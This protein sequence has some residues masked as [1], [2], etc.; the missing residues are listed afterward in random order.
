MYRVQP[1]KD[2][3]IGEIKKIQAKCLTEKGCA[4]PG[5][6]TAA[7]TEEE[8][9]QF[10]KENYGQWLRVAK[11]GEKIIGYIIARPVEQSEECGIT[12]DMFSTGEMPEG[13]TMVILSVAAD[14]EL[15]GK[16][17]SQYMEE[18]YMDLRDEIYV[19]LLRVLIIESRI[20]G[21]FDRVLITCPESRMKYYEELGFHELCVSET[22]R[23]GSEETLHDMEYFLEGCQGNCGFCKA[24]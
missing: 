24:C 17:T 9:L 1:V 12:D 3:E 8:Q 23:I 13:R 4:V 7:W 11:D 10:M 5:R 22:K 14:N 19:M 2:N 21:E 20:T 18:Y 6:A 16:A 15:E